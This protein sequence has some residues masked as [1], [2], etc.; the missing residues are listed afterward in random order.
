MD[1][2]NTLVK[3]FYS[4]LN[5]LVIKVPLCEVPVKEWSVGKPLVEVPPNVGRLGEPKDKKRFYLKLKKQDHK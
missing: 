3:I 4:S 1:Q 5:I 2:Q